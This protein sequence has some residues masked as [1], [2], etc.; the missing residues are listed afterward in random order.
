M[1]KIS[2]KEFPEYERYPNQGITRYSDSKVFD[3]EFEKD[4]VY[5]DLKLYIEIEYTRFYGKMTFESPEEDDSSVT[6]WS[7][8]VIS[9]TE[10]YKEKTHNLVDR[11]LRKIERWIDNYIE[12]V[13]E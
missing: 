1:I 13:D 11:E 6:K 12:F 3:V 8:E 7:I 10:T 9:G 4:D 5:Y 2:I